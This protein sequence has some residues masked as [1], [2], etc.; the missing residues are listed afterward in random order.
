[1]GVTLDQTRAVILAG[2]AG[3]RIQHL[4][5][6]IPKPMVP[7]AGKPFLEWVVRFLAKQGITDV[8]IST[9]Y[10]AGHIAAHFDR[11]P[12]PGVSV[13]C[14]PEPQPLGTA[15]GFLHAIAGRLHEPGPWLVCNGDSLVLTG[16][17]AML[18]KLVTED[19]LEA[20]FLGVEVTDCSRYGSLEI[21]AS[22]RLL[23]FVEKRPGA[24]LI[25]AGAYLFTPS[26]PP[27]L[28][29]QRPLSFESEVFPALLASG[30]AMGVSPTAAPFLDIGTEATL[31][32]ATE[33]VARHRDFFL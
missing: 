32:S 33:F 21:N 14:L 5:P 25:N 31:N 11:L 9:G 2:G 23:R 3:T 12:I 6:D 29:S 16:L 27:R 17:G 10:R 24:G 15:G 19:R 8:T 13:R 28:P 4:I 7:V 1:M 22:G 18:A 20:V 30:V 26:L